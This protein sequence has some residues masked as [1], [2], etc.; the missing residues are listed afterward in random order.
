MFYHTGRPQW[1][2]SKELAYSGGA[3]GDM[4]LIL[5]LGEAH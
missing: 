5:V 2:R 1:L 3:T 4:V